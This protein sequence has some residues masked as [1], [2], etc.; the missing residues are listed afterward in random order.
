MELKPGFKETVV[1]AIPKDWECTNVRGIASAARN[2]IAG[3]PFGSD[4]VSADYVNFGVP[5]IRGQN[6]GGQWVGGN[7]AFVTEDK[8][9]SL[10]SNLARPHDIVF[11][12][13]GTL[14]QVSL[15]PNEPF[16]AYLISQSQMKLSSNRTIADPL[17]YYYVFTSDDQQSRI[18]GGT[19]QTGVPHINLGILKD[20]PV[21]RPPIAEQRAIAAALSDIDALLEGLGRLIAKKCDLKKAAMQ[22]LLTG[23]IRLPG[24]FGKWKLK[25]LADCLRTV[26]DY[27][28]NAPAVVYSERLPTYIRITDISVDGRFRPAPRVSVKSFFSDQYLLTEGDIVFTRTGASVGKAYCYRLED[29]PLVFAGFLIRVRP[30]ADALMPAYLAAY[31][32]TKPYWDW[33]T[34]MS[35]RSG[36]PG[37]NGKE[38]GQL[39]INLPPPAEQTAIAAV[40][41][42]MDTEIST[43]ESRRIKTRALK[44]SMMQ[45]LLTGRI[46][47]V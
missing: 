3:G 37:I 47:L 23:Q 35:M 4:L 19:I 42:D 28:I 36:Q 5:V 16:A 9:K 22:Q 29:G 38:Y 2:A 17:F 41:S 8:A 14:G 45:E 31:A 6:M 32:T 27:G 12:Q 10:D 44:Q 39:P 13:R 46:R 21:Q 20:I 43:L 26:P 11:T 40:L 25:V 30:D 1:G 7:F 15:V 34:L 24:F 33:V 18:R